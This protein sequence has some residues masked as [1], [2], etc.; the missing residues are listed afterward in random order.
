MR[1]AIIGSGL[2]GLSAAVRLATAGHDVTVLEKNERIGGKM[3]VLELGGYRFD[4]GPTLLT[5]PFV[6]RDLFASAGKRLED[7]LD[8][9]PLDPACRYIYPDG[10]MLDAHSDTARM[11]DALSSFSPTDAGA[12][13]RFLAHAKGVYDAAAEPFLYGSFGSWSF[14]D[15]LRSLKHLSAVAKLDSSR[16]L[17]ACVASYFS[18]PRLVQLFDRFATYNGSSPYR[19]PATLAIIPYVEFAFGGWYPRG[20]VYGIANAI[21]SLAM[22]LGV[23]IRT[24]TSVDR[25]LTIGNRV[26]GVRI[27]GGE[28]LLADAVISNADPAYTMDALLAADRIVS[29]MRQDR[30]EPSMAGLILY[31]GVKRTWP[32]LRQHNIFFS[33][34]YR[35][36]FAQLDAGQLADDPTVYVCASSLVDPDHAPEGCMNLFVMV[37]APA[38]DGRIDWSA[39]RAAYRDRIIA[40]LERMGLDGLGEAIAE[41]AM[42]APDEFETRYNAPHGSIYGTASNDRYA[43][44]RRPPNRS[45]ALRG[46]YFASGSAHPGGG[47]PLVLL[48]GKHAADL[49]A[50][51]YA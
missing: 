16:S 21:G 50:R 51:D 11:E 28:P 7:A 38:L 39:M 45:S 9:L 1:I 32:L 6:L 48:S 24:G 34:D 42:L 22:E 47:I 41:E 33:S 12:F 19:A 18:D 15:I 27:S 2:G 31:L 49:I 44:F 17:H 13:A 43:A 46:L 25:I 8:L 23:T 40:K 5:M 26:A 20:G 36:E 4:T 14:G 30:N 10:S 37:N 35:A 3:N 29:A